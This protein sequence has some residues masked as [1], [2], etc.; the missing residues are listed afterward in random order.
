MY[1]SN[2]IAKDWWDEVHVII[3]GA[4]IK[5]FVESESIQKAVKEASATGV[6]FSACIACAK[7]LNLEDEVKATG[8][9]LDYMGAVLT[10]AIQGEN[11]HLITI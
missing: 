9:E 8:I 2:A 11:E 3:W 10:D 7:K 4:T 5:L 6:K 1:A